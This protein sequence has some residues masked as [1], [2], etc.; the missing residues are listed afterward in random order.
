MAFGLLSVAGVSDVVGGYYV[1]YARA[2]HVCVSGERRV[3]PPPPPPLLPCSLPPLSPLLFLMQM[4]GL[5][6]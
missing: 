4:D 3:A 1:L 2:L 6:A 5:I